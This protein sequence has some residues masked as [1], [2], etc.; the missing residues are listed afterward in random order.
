M[1]MLKKQLSFMN[2]AAGVTA[3]VNLPLGPTYERWV[4]QLGGTT[5]TKHT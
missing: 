4:F 5:F 3:T 2:V 1:G